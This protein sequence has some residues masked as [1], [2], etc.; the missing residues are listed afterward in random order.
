MAEALM[1]NALTKGPGTRGEDLRNARVFCIFA[2]LR[3]PGVLLPTD[4]NQIE[5]FNRKIAAAD[6]QLVQ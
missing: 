1:V 3:D 5:K 2:G 4:A 6:Q